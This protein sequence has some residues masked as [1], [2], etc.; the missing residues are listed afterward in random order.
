MSSLKPTRLVWA[1]LAA[2]LALAGCA[3]G[4]EPAADTPSPTVEETDD[5]DAVEGATE[6]AANVPRVAYTYDGGIVVLDANSLEQVADIPLAGF[7]RLNPAGD[8][9]HVLVS[10]TG[11]F[12]LLDLGTY[13]TPHGDHDHYYTADPVLTDLKFPAEKPGH[14][15]RHDD[16]TVMFD[17]GTGKVTVVESDEIGD[18][19]A[20]QR[21]YTTPTPHHGVAVQLHDGTLLV[22]EGTSEARSGVRVLDASDKE[23]AASDECPGVHGEAMAA[24]DAALFG[25]E[26]GVLLYVD[27]QFTK[28]AA[29]T[30]YGRIGNQSALDSSPVVL[31]D[32]KS[33][34]D[35]ELERPTRVSL[36][37]T[38]AATLTLVD[39]PASY[40]FRSLAR[41]ADGAALVLGTDGQLHVIDVTTAQLAA[42]YPVVQAWTEPDEW[43]QP[44]P[45]IT[46]LDG[47]AYIT[48]PA[49][50]KLHVVYPA[51]GEI[52]KTADLTQTPNEITGV[53]GD[54]GG[55]EHDHED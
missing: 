27:G 46:M 31:G 38:A 42:S 1:A 7:N 50:K 29:P 48:D 15:V 55:G 24:D 3:A 43:Q 36:T 25:C 12:Q 6:Q 34:P 21:L 5:V 52:W 51:T 39:L 49:A 8:G 45:T 23:I 26:D 13:G 37:D 44:R 28:L 54:G 41:A 10:T 47:M 30:P 11:G 4:D 35:A 2:S 53:M 9:R 33:D 14:V 17:D 19:D 20:E 16:A 32:Y 40:S 22:T 18:P